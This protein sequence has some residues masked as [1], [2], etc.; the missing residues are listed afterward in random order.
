M[1]GLHVRLLSFDDDPPIG[2]QGVV[3]LHLRKEL[4]RQGV[5]TDTIASRGAYAHPYRKIL[6]RAPLDFSIMVNQL[7]PQLWQG[8]DLLHVQ[9]GPGG[10]LLLRRPHIPVVY[11][12]NHT[13]SQ[14][15]GR[16]S[17]KRSLSPLEAL[18]YRR[19]AQVIAISSSTADELLRMGIPARHVH[20]V[21]PGVERP[22]LKKPVE[23]DPLRVI[24][25]GR[26]EKEKGVMDAL[27]AM[28]EL[29]HLVKGVSGVIVGDGARRAEVRSLARQNGIS[30][31]GKVS[32]ARLL[33]EMAS[34]SV[35]L[36][37]SHYE[38]LGLVAL[39]AAALGTVPVG[40]AVPGLTDA[41]DG[42]GFAVTPFSP[43]A[44][45]SM[46]HSLLTEPQM[47]EEQSRKGREKVEMEYSW[48][49]S[50]RETVAVY[51]QALGQASS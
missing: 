14:A 32:R 29:R 12:A 40:Y 35:L 48:E 28:I 16:T 34:A 36:M 42:T 22:V 44:L 33:A 39:E 20:L 43:P 15:H 41:L 13:Y 6:H 19:A 11:S 18:A 4:E 17:F 27:T 10:V 45:I 5:Y 2:G 25:V 21:H 7:G 49:T 46:A 38:G 30:V 3:V 23:R 9:G 26:L 51:R 50:V 47:W 31:L 8:A 24:F 37:P 1:T